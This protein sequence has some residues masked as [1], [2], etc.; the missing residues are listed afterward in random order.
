MPNHADGDPEPPQCALLAFL[1]R[2][3]PHE[4]HGH[5]SILTKFLGRHR[6][7]VRREQVES[8]GRR[9]R[10]DHRD[11]WSVRA[12]HEAAP[13]VELL[14]RQAKAARRIEG[15]R[16]R[17]IL[18]R[19][20]RLRTGGSARRPKFLPATPRTRPGSAAAGYLCRD[21]RAQEGSRRR[22][23]AAD[24][25]GDSTRADVDAAVARFRGRP[26]RPQGGGPARVALAS[27]SRR[28][29]SRP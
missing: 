13:L 8:H 25:R 29:R 3:N 2:A 20:P 26:R 14:E 1:L 27:I 21:H 10:S 23:D 6:R 17:R 24:G 28:G 4:H 19:S 12:G 22:A 18:K 9:R 7:L 11:D 16:T 15:K 5:M